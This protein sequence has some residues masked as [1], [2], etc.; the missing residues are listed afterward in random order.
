MCCA[1]PTTSRTFW[2]LPILIY[3]EIK[4]SSD[5][6][7]CVIHSSISDKSSLKKTGDSDAEPSQYMV[8]SV[9]GPCID[10]M[11]AGKTLKEVDVNLPYLQ[12]MF[13]KEDYISFMALYRRCTFIRCCINPSMI[14]KAISLEVLTNAQPHQRMRHPMSS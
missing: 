13:V 6:Q 1:R 9:S 8:R 2:L 11:K 3:M 4:I 14:E 5:Q 10:A 12:V 7:L